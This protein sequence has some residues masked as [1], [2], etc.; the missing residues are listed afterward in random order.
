M[1]ICLFRIILTQR[2][3]KSNCLWKIHKTQTGRRER[4]QRVQPTQTHRA[5]RS[6]TFPV[7]SSQLSLVKDIFALGQI[8]LG[9]QLKCMCV[10]LRYWASARLWSSG[11][12]ER[13]DT[14]ASLTFT[15]PLSVFTARSCGSSLEVPGK[16]SC[17]GGKKPTPRTR[18]TE[19]ASRLFLVRVSGR[20]Q[21]KCQG[22]VPS[23]A[24]KPS[25]F[26]AKRNSNT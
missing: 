6:E 7:V 24:G 2:K 8:A 11:E 16:V 14:F 12:P 25:T 5:S 20:C 18:R 10:S 19:G 26:V 23:Q 17:R 4:H 21:C 22:N 13:K 1:T 15:G 3:K 9:T